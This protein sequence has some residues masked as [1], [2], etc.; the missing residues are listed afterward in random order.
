[1][2]ALLISLL[3]GAAGI[4]STLAGLAWDAWLH[5]ADPTLAQRE[6]I[7]T[8]TNPGHALLGLGVL[9]TCGGILAALHIAWGMA[10]PRGFLGKPYV[11]TLSMRLSALLSIGAVVF[12]LAISSSGHEHAHANEEDAHA[13]TE[14]AVEAAPAGALLT[15]DDSLD[16]PVTHTHATTANDDEAAPIATHRHEPAAPLSNADT[17]TAAHH[18]SDVVGM[19]EEIACGN[20]LV[21]ATREATARFADIN[22][23]LAE[24]YRNNPDKPGATHYGNPAYKRDGKIMDLAHPESLVYYTNPKTGESVLLGALF[25]M[26][27]GEDGPQPCGAVTS[28]HTHAACA[29]RATGDVIPVEAGTPCAEGYRY[30]ESVQMMHVC[31]VPGRKNGVAPVS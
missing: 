25:T 4:A 1:M 5:A 9:L 8:L 24:G 6:G 13:H 10:K 12:A 26:P 29:D 23:A 27:R 20:G 18:H 22:V 3:A 19:A 16:G 11:R 28:W 14:A 7:F 2:K 15:G 21:R 30:G 17:T 31:F